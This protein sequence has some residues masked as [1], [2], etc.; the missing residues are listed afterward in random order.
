M[1]RQQGERRRKRST[2]LSQT[3]SVE[4][5]SESEEHTWKKCLCTG[6]KPQCLRFFITNLIGELYCHQSTL[7]EESFALLQI[8]FVSGR[9][10]SLSQLLSSSC[11]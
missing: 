1:T 6:L 2:V 3:L 11:D 8:I 5:R 9:I 4:E 10:I 7:K